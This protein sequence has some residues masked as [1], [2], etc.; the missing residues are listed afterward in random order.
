MVNGFCLGLVVIQND[1]L[2]GKLKSI[3][4]QVGFEAG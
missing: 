4:L 1:A 2:L 3:F